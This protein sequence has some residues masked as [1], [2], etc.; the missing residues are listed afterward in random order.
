MGYSLLLRALCLDVLVPCIVNHT[1]RT[2]ILPRN[3]NRYTT[4]KTA[5]NDRVLNLNFTSA[6]ANTWLL[7]L[8]YVCILLNHLA[9]AA[10]GCKSPLQVL[11]GQQPEISKLLHFSFYE[12]IYYST[13]SNSF[14]STSTEAQGWLVGVSIHIG[15]ALPY[16]LIT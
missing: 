11:T 10:I 13:Y 15:D 14:T 12:P 6:P 3:E 8:E 4:I 5:T 16:K 1:T 9:S 7:A 2:K